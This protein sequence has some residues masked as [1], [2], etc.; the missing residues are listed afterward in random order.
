MA[1]LVAKAKRMGV[2]PESYARRL[3]EDG[4]GL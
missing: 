4:L 2:A 1:E 3:V